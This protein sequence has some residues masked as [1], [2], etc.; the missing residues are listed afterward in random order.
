M[1][2]SAQTHLRLAEAIAKPVTGLLS[3]VFNLPWTSRK[4]NQD[5][6]ALLV[7]RLVARAV[8]DD[9]LVERLG[10]RLPREPSANRLLVLGMDVVRPRPGR[11]ITAWPVWGNSLERHRLGFAELGPGAVARLIPL[12]QEVGEL[13][14]IKR[15]IALPP[16]VA[17]VLDH[18]RKQL[19]ILVSPTDVR[20][21]LIPDHAAN[22]VGHDRLE[23]AVVEVCRPILIDDR[24]APPGLVRRLRCAAPPRVGGLWLP[25]AARLLVKLRAGFLLIEARHVLCPTARASVGRADC[26]PAN[27]D[28]P[29]PH[30]PNRPTRL[31]INPIGTFTFCS[32]SRPKK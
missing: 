21:A 3:T 16:V 13:H 7:H 28:E 12:G 11:S 23:P 5:R 14:P 17:P 15:E 24:I 20:F 4:P 10:E 32:M 30:T 2:A 25:T 26:L 8:V 19:A 31:S 29:T 27:R 18:Q 6:A 9:V 1:V 22:R